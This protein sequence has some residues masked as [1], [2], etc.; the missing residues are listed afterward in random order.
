[1]LVDGK[2]ASRAYGAPYAENHRF[3]FLRKRCLSACWAASQTLNTAN[4]LQATP[5]ADA[6]EFCVLSPVKMIVLC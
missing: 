1:M 2:L 5:P 3:R 6:L 4:S